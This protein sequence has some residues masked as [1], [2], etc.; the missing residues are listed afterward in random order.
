MSV[1]YRCSRASDICLFCVSD[2]LSDESDVDSSEISSHESHPNQLTNAQLQ[3]QH[4][5]GSVCHKISESLVFNQRLLSLSLGLCVRRGPR[6]VSSLPDQ[7]YDR[8]IPLEEKSVSFSDETA[9]ES[10]QLM[11]SP[12]RA[13]YHSLLLHPSLPERHQSMRLDRDLLEMSFGCR[14]LVMANACV[15]THPLPD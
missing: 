5:K 3:R 11:H 13:G 12:Q 4:F 14:F 8:T 1:N 2:G 7:S 9:T 10:D 6:T 15:A